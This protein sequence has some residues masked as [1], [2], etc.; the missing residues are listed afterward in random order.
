MTKDKALR[1]TTNCG[2]VHRIERLLNKRE[3]MT[4]RFKTR[5]INHEHLE[6]VFGEPDMTFSDAVSVRSVGV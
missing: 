5:G 4:P 2:F 6:G 1:R 3:E